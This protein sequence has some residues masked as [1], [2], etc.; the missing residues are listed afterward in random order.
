MLLALLCCASPA[1][2]ARRLPRRTLTGA[3]CQLQA[4]AMLI[5]HEIYVYYLSGSDL[6]SV[7]SA[8]LSERL[9]CSV[10]ISCELT[11]HVGQTIQEAGQTPVC[12]SNP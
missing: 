10:G 3:I 8:M 12:C 6:F 11:M 1:A 4:P 7:D 9:K 2:C 5:Y